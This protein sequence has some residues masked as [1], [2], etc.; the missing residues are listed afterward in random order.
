[1]PKDSS[2]PGSLEL[3]RSFV[4]SIDIE[5]PETIDG[6]SDVGAARLWLADAG[7]APDGLE[8]GSLSELRA[9]REAIRAVLM[10]HAGEADEAA[11]WQ[12]L[13][14]QLG[15]ISVELRLAGV[16]EVAL[17]AP[18]PAGAP[19]LRGAL[20]AAIY[21]AVR[22]GTWRRLKACRKRSCLFA[23]YDKTK[24]GGGVW[25]SMD[26]CG[27]QAKAHRRRQRERGEASS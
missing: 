2:A 7:F 15:P 3:V 5:H 8:A 11:A 6:L 16:G 23:F 24:N 14:S 25:C 22:D 4:N 19:A 1:M 17:E 10:A 27:N 13:A 20:A 26:T 21:D 18:A 12:T 9:L